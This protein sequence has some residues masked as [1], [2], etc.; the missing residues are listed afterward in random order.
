M[1]GAYKRGPTLQSQTFTD[2]DAQRAIPFDEF[3][4]PRAIVEF[5]QFLAAV[6]CP[7]SLAFSNGI[8]GLVS[9]HGYC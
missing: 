6:R 5:S 1:G 4:K 8:N 2:P 9:W 3:R 7:W